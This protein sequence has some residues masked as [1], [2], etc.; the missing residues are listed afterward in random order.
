M[1]LYTNFCISLVTSTRLKLANPDGTPLPGNQKVDEWFSS[2]DEKI[3]TF[4]EN[5]GR[6]LIEW[7]GTVLA[8]IVDIIAVGCYLF[9]WFYVVKFMFFHSEKDM[10]RVAFVFMC[11]L[12]LRILSK[13]L[14]LDITPT[15]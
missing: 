4:F 1:N 11:L 10:P 5:L 14:Q 2:W 3:A 8:W 13:L 7:L 15:P 12:L 6:Q 9:I